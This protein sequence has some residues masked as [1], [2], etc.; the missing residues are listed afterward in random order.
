MR[1]S[2]PTGAVFALTLL[3]VSA[4]QAQNYAPSDVLSASR[5]GTMAC[6]DFARMGKDARDRLVSEATS[7][8]PGRSLAGVTITTTIPDTGETID[9]SPGNNST[10]PGTP[11]TAG[12][13][14]AACQASPPSTT[15]RDAYARS[16]PGPTMLQTT[17]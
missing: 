16:N 7:S 3:A 15:L 8:A 2:I 1:I 4:A 13:L 17:E 12:Q 6:G 5:L 11:L 9:Q 10:V 14:I